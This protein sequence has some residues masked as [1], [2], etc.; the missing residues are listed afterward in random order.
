M[1]FNLENHEIHVEKIH[2]NLCPALLYEKALSSEKGSVLTNNGALAVCSGRK[3]GRSPSDKRI[4]EHRDSSGDIWW[5]DVNVKLPDKVF[6]INWERA[7]DYLNTQDELFVVDGFGGW[8]PEHRIKVRI[9]CSRA[10]HALFMHNM[11]IR[12]SK[13]ELVAFGEPEYVIFNAGK[14]PAN[15]YTDGM[16]SDTSIDLDLERKQ[17]VILGS[18]Y[19]GEMKKGVF[20]DKGYKLLRETLAGQGPEAGS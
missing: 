5:G 4:V 9:I 19:A 10:Y 1:S 14:F 2:R 11:L 17:L 18:E 20:T 8:D 15:R 13:A 3:S 6:M 7:I 12:P 16:T